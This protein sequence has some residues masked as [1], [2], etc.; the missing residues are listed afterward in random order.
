MPKTK[1]EK[2]S[3]GSEKNGEKVWQVLVVV[4][5]V[6]VFNY[7]ASALDSYISGRRKPFLAVRYGW[8]HKAANNRVHPPMEA[9]KKFFEGN[10]D[11]LI[12]D[13]D[14]QGVSD[15]FHQRLQEEDFS[16]DVASVLTGIQVVASIRE[17]VEIPIVAFSSYADCVGVK[18]ALKKISPSGKLNVSL[19][20]RC[21]HVD[22]TVAWMASR[23]ALVFEALRLAGGEGKECFFSFSQEK[24]EEYIQRL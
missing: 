11:L 23:D 6:S 1:K 13:L 7:I 18:G 8:D 16:L 14:M 10:Y 5:L 15:E 20:K 21:H 4:N 2:Q 9:V 22:T 17:R 24:S 19:V 3:Q 12:I